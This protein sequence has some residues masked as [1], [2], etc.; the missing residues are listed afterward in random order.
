MKTVV[1]GTFP[2]KTSSYVNAA[3]KDGHAGV[4]IG[5]EITGG[6]HNVWVEN[7]RMD[8]PELDRIIRIKSNPMRGGNVENVF[9][10]NITVGECKQSILGIEQKYWHVDEASVSASLR[11]Y[12]PGKYYQQEKP[13]CASS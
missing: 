4:A 10:R 13:V 1:T 12:P 3:W 7:C 9:V 5:S 8:S 2:A 11:E 6:C